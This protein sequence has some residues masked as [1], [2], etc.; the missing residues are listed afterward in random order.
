MMALVE[1]N[2]R[3]T[4]GLAG[5]VSNLVS[6]VMNWNTNRVTRDALYSLTERELDDI[7]L[8]RADIDMMSFTRRS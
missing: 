8:N 5:A 6:A 4:T 1:M 7:G 2:A 3:R